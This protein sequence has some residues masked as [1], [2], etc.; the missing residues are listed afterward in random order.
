M[1]MINLAA[2]KKIPIAAE[3]VENLPLS[4]D[5]YKIILNGQE[6][7]Q[8]AI[9]GQFISILCKDLVLRRPFSIANVEG[10]SIHIIYKLKGEGTEY[11]SQLKSGEKINFIGPFGNGFNITHQKA[12]LVGAGVGTAPLIFLS[13]ELT[14]KQIPYILA[15]GFQK[16]VDIPELNPDKDYI[17][18]ED[19]SSKYSGLVIDHLEEII[20]THK[21]EKIYSCGPTPVLK[22]VVEIANKY[23]IKSELALERKFAC[24]TG[25]CMGC[26]IHIRENNEIKNKRICKDGPVF[27]GGSIVW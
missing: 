11:I 25:V 24:G 20:N 18:T 23:N 1:E 3:I 2:N 12:L 5:I 21:P 16:S 6:A 10:E 27:D 4:D 9:P 7:A 8:K 15:A 22:Y 26:T 14:K 13:K 19:S 17:I